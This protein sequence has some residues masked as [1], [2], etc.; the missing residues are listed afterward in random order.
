MPLKSGEIKLSCTEVHLKELKVRAREAILR[1]LRERKWNTVR[2]PGK[3]RKVLLSRKD[4]PEVYRRLLK[5]KFINNR[6]LHYLKRRYI[7]MLSI[8]GEDALD[9]MFDL[10]LKD[11]KAEVY[12]FP[13]DNRVRFDIFNG[14]LF[15]VIEENGER[16]S[17][18]FPDAVECVKR[19]LS[20]WNA[21]FVGTVAEIL[22]V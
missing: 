1:S 11:R 2:V 5:G 9:G 16:V 4:L 10:L 19:C 7:N 14:K 21:Q 12:W 22:D 15:G 3:Y 8:D 6:T 18:V 20:R 17:L 13:F